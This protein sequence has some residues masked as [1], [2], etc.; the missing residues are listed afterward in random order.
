MFQGH[1]EFTPSAVR[2][3]VEKIAAAADPDGD[4]APGTHFNAVVSMQSQGVSKE[5]VLESAAVPAQRDADAVASLF[6]KVFGVL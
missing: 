5:A 2:G 1:P 4:D 3:F 6:L